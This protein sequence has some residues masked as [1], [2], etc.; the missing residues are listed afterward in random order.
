M[1]RRRKKTTFF[2]PFSLG[3]YNQSLCQG[4]SRFVF[5]PAMSSK[6]RSTTQKPIR[7]G[8]FFI[9]LAVFGMGVA[10][11]IW[12]WDHTEPIRKSGDFTNAW[13]WG[14]TV[15]SDAQ[16]I[17]EHQPGRGNQVEA[18]FLAYRNLYGRVLQKNE[19]D[20]FKLDYPPLRLLVMSLWV[21]WVKT[22]WPELVKPGPNELSPLLAINLLMQAL[23]AVGIYHLVRLVVVRSDYDALVPCL[24]K[25]GSV[26][27]AASA[28]LAWFN[29]ALILNA[30]AWPQWDAWV[31]PPFL[32][33]ALAALDSRW[34]TAGVLI[35]AGS[36]F[37]GQAVIIAPVFLAWAWAFDG[38]RASLRFVAGLLTISA[39]IASPWLLHGLG[40]AGWGVLAVGFVLPLAWAF[41]FQRKDETPWACAAVAVVFFALGALSS[42][43]FTWL[44]VGFLFGTE[45]YPRLFM[46]AAYNLPAVLA[47]WGWGLKDPTGPWLDGPGLT[48]QSSLRI[49]YAV[50]VLL[51]GYAIAYYL[52]L[53]SPRVLAALAFPW[54]LMFAI[55]GQMHERYLVWGAVVTAMSAVWNVRFLLF[56]LLVT[57]G[58]AGMMLTSML[59]TTGE[60]FLP[61]IFP[62][63]QRIHWGAA[64]FFCLIFLLVG[65]SILFEPARAL[66]K[67]LRERGEGLFRQGRASSGSFRGKT[68]RE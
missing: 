7:Y 67:A 38:G 55:L 2:K 65:W 9:L 54:I 57:M 24:I 63:L 4:P 43:G 28:I 49:A 30:H 13:R 29:P 46:G 62:I 12:T 15:V 35:G 14:G 3:K 45:K 19:E 51:N 10:V 23:T 11:R 68:L 37:K 18:F 61:G 39:L 25:N 64:V 22:A 31:L 16:E 50:G 36:F 40:V 17:V 53:Q 20:P 59:R 32:F 26:M 27:A 8:R 42:D 56:H 34:F 5:M 33:A 21:C 41:L 44:K 52:K 6:C 48:L 47:G 1:T 60:T 66:I 58:A